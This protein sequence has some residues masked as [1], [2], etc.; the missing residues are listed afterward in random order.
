MF[1]KATSY[2]LLILLI[3]SCQNNDQNLTVV[4]KYY[5][6]TTAQ[7][8][9]ISK[10]IDY[11]GELKSFNSTLVASKIPGKL[12]S[13]EFS[14]GDFVEKDQLLATLEGQEFYSQLDTSQEVLSAVGNLKESTNAM[15]DQ[16]IEVAQLKVNQA[17]TAVEVAEISL[18]GASSGLSDTENVST[19]QL[20]TIEKQ[21]DE[22]E[23]TIE[24]S[25]QNFLDTKEVL[26]QKRTNLY[27]NAKSALSQSIVPVTSSFTFLDEIGGV[28][29]EKKSSNDLYDKY[30]GTK[31]TEL[32]NQAKNNFTKLYPRY[33][34]FIADYEEKIVRQ[35]E[36]DEVEINQFLL[37]SYQFLLDLKD[38]LNLAFNVVDN[39]IEAPAFTLETINNLKEDVSTLAVTIENTIMSVEGNFV[40]GI[41][42]MIDNISQFNK[43]SQLQLDSLAREIDLYEKQLETLEQTYKQTQAVNKG[44]I[45]DITTQRH[46]QDKQLELAQQQLAEA[47]NS[48]ASLQEQKKAALAEIASNQSQTQGQIAQS[49]VSVDNTMVKAPFAGVIT[50]KLVEV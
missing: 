31:N 40:V 41:K 45:T 32:K 30:L 7:T 19:Q 18:Q 14:A 22:L 9:T 21:I 37:E 4:Q 5:E 8:G 15:F 49:E 16:Q 10:E 11:T 35:A 17:Q 27:N 12:S 3:S 13:L 6:L 20:V 34:Q 50:E 39:S 25:E 23:T 29:D 24:F 36:L 26:I 2:L 44:K 42:G 46:V 1:K 33:E 28:T 48:L 43:E 38:M 47:N